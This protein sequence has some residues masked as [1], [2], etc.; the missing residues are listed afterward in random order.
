MA[1]EVRPI[2][3]IVT[4][5]VTM[6]KCVN[7][8]T[9]VT[10]GDQLK[11][12]TKRTVADSVTGTGAPPNGAESIPVVVTQTATERNLTVPQCGTVTATVTGDDRANSTAVKRILTAVPR[13]VAMTGV[14]PNIVQLIFVVV[15][16]AVVGLI[17]TLIR[18]SAATE[19]V[20]ADRVNVLNRMEAVIGL[21]TGVRHIRVTVTIANLTVA[22]KEVTDSVVVLLIR[23][24][25]TNGVTNKV[26][27]SIVK[28]RIQ[29]TIVDQV[30]M[31]FVMMQILLFRSN[32]ILAVVRMLM[33]PEAGAPGL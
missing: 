8:T 32:D 22:R 29:V 3:V 26:A 1:S 9:T 4:A 12:T 24:T 33:R 7:V 6:H 10:V 2:F 25:V 14:M 28:C 27:Q 31:L 23:I 19:T 17:L 5:T 30:I 15:T 20:T 13:T 18:R 11:Q 21:V 16:A